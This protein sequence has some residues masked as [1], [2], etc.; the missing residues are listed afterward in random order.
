MTTRQRV[1]AGALLASVGALLLLA[2]PSP[3]PSPPPSPKPTT[4]ASA[5]DA[6]LPSD[7]ADAKPLDAGPPR[8][9]PGPCVATM[10]N[11]GPLSDDAIALAL[12]PDFD[13]DRYATLVREL[14]G[15]GAP[16]DANPL[17][18][19]NAERRD[20]PEGLAEVTSCQGDTISLYDRASRV[21]VVRASLTTSSDVPADAGLTDIVAV[22]VL[23]GFQGG[24]CDEPAGFLALVRQRGRVVEIVASEPWSGFA[25]SDRFGDLSAVPWGD[26]FVLLEDVEEASGE[27]M[28]NT[29]F[30]RVL[31]LDEKR[32][33][34]LGS[35][36]VWLDQQ[37]A[38]PEEAAPWKANMAA[39]IE[40][41]DS[42]VVSHEVWTFARAKPGSN[43][44]L[45]PLPGKPV[46]TKKLDRTY[47]IV[48]AGLVADPPESVLPRP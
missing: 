15:D 33:A 41:T 9:G 25:C 34:S 2:R 47:R 3:N 4:D 28:S 19:F 20:E 23:V 40:S 21:R 27:Q 48:D 11:D 5:A 13:L 30:K 45:E 32:L 24:L 7:A 14:P 10:P 8:R 42:G 22:R 1:I 43:A 18:P 29:R 38:D 16:A 46:R 39:T 35:I 44:S 17:R 26:G 12:L 37:R 36:E 31:R 6:P